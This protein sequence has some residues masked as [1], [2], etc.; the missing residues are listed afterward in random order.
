VPSREQLRRVVGGPAFGI[1]TESDDIWNG[2]KHNK[3]GTLMSEKHIT[4]REARLELFLAWCALDSL[5]ARFASAPP[6]TED[7]GLFV[8]PITESLADVEVALK[9][10]RTFVAQQD[11]DG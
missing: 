3:K 9:T 1:F 6:D 10:L 7:L 11:P 8:Q 4:V 5:K 2:T